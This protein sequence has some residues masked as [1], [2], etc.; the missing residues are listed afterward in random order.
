MNTAQF[1]ISID[2]GSTYIKGALFKADQRGQQQL[3]ASLISPTM[4][5]EGALSQVFDQLNEV[6]IKKSSNASPDLVLIGHPPDLKIF[7]QANSVAKISHEE[8]FTTVVKRLSSTGTV[9]AIDIGSRRT[10]V[11][12]GRFGKTTVES[13][14]YGVGQEIWNV[15]RKYIPT[16]QVKSWMSYDISEEE[17]ENYAANKSIYPHAIPATPMEMAIEQTVAKLIMKK[18]SQELPFPWEDIQQ[19]VLSG[20]VLTQP[21]IAAQS[22][23][24]MLD[25]LQPLH[26]VQVLADT[27]ATVYACGGVF[28]FWSA[29]DYRVA[30][31]VLHQ[32]LQPLGTI[33]SFAGQGRKQKLAKIRLDT[34]LST[35]QVLEVSDGEIVTI[36]MADQDIGQVA[37]KSSSRAAAKSNVPNELPVAG[38]EI[39]LIIDG[40][41]RPLELPKQ[42]R[43]RRQILKNWERQLD[44]S[45]R[46]G[47]IGGAS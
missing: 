40:R 38:G 8:A 36:P 11:S 46:V 3:I 33:I 14:P 26:S 47:E 6:A 1:V 44:V 42:D 28:D 7:S 4:D 35:E 27:S 24:T 21:S 19:V 25:G 2:V 45:D 32:T 37:I 30:R 15:L 22:V 29:N 20:S 34:G 13:F 43:E 39:G 18:I 12:L 31:S 16:S 5:E 17:I 23:M 41:S 9:V 10:M